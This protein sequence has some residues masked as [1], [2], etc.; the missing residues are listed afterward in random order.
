MP[1][2]FT[3][4][5]VHE[6]N[7]RTTDT[8]Y[9][10]LQIAKPGE[11][12]SARRQLS[13]IIRFVMDGEGFT[14]VDGKR[15]PMKK[16]DAIVI[17]GYHWYD[18]ENKSDEPVIWLDGSNV[19]PNSHLLSLV[20]V[21]PDVYQNSQYSS[22]LCEDCKLLFPW[23]RVEAF[24]NAQEGPYAVYHYSFGDSKPI[25]TDITLQAERV[26]GYHSTTRTH[27]IGSFIYHCFEGQG[28]T[29]METPLEKTETIHWT[30][31]DIFVVPANSTIRHVSTS[32]RR[33]Y[34]V[35][36]TD[37]PVLEMMEILKHR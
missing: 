33:A 32:D 13:F 20:P 7:F 3:E 25:S 30:T 28:Y 14:S 15:M 35:G 23:K 34:L 4:S 11:I 26:D 1:N 9:G 12:A 21:N 8:L 24:L 19:H 16:G 2:G 36:F 10:G 6:D 27:E 18:H 5:Y 37:R 29:E 31:G 17:T 22:R